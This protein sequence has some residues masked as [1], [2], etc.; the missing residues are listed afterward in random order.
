MSTQ[1]IAY[2]LESSQLKLVKE[3][4]ISCLIPLFWN[5]YLLLELD[6]K[7]NIYFYPD[8]GPVQI[9]TKRIL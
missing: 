5:L 3:L 7:G 4:V 9:E 8:S 6:A 1:N 2:C